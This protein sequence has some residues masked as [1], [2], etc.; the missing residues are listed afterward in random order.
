M[1]L[2]AALG[3]E[4]EIVGTVICGDTYFGENMEKATEE[5]LALIEK[6]KPDLSWLGRPSMR[7]DTE[8]PAAL[9]A[10]R[11]QR[12][13]GIPVVTGMYPENPGVD[14]FRKQCLHQS[15]PATAP[16]ACARLCPRWQSLHS[17]SQKGEPTD[18]ATDGYLPAGSGRTTSPRSAA[19]QR[20][21]EM[22]VKK[23]SD[24]DFVTE[25]PMPEFDRVE[26]NPPI[27]DISKATIALVTSG[28]N[29]AE[30]A[31]PTT[32]SRR[33]RRSSASTP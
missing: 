24:K 7:D 6:Y 31:T 13:F 20:A 18:P 15:R 12:S 33:R 1:A 4:A 16:L 5:V 10:R 2:A 3:D 29:R 23:L 17:N 27:A 25:Y 26:P 22:L 19:L 21:V 28:R 30:R 11:W 9:C 32:S 14:M 8:P